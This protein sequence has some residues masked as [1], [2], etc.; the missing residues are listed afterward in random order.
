MAGTWLT[1][2]GAAGAMLAAGD[3]RFQELLWLAALAVLTGLG[4]LIKIYQNKKGQKERE[5]KVQE[6]LRQ[7]GEAEAGPARASAPGRLPP[8]A[9]GRAGVPPA[10]PSPAPSAASQAR[11][12]SAGP[13]ERGAAPSGGAATGVR[14]PGGAGGRPAQPPARPAGAPA[15]PAGEPSVVEQARANMARSR[16]REKS[17]TTAQAR[18]KVPVRV[19]ANLPPVGASGEKPAA[20]AAGPVHAAAEVTGAAAEFFRLEN[21][22]QLAQAILASEVLGEPLAWRGHRVGEF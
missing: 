19:R 10:R 11:P 4:R 18:S 20:A 2:F 16:L 15:R 17:Q 14:Q 6:R 9:R 13:R 1:G 21:T 12:V 5:G 22:A 3:D 7:G 8:Y